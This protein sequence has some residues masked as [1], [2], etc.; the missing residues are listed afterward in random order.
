M[1]TIQ[2]NDLVWVRG[3]QVRVLSIDYRTGSALVQLGGRQS[4]V[5]ISDLRRQ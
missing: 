5:N 4:I 3:F 1:T 2:K